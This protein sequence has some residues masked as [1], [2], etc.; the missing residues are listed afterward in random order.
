MNKPIIDDTNREILR[1]L[2]EN[3]RRPY[4]SIAKA[5]NLSTPS[6]SARIDQL[7]QN[8]VIRRFTIDLDFSQY[9][10]RLHVMVRLLPEFAKTESVRKSILNSTHIENVFT[11]AKGEI[12]VVGSLPRDSIGQWMLENLP[13]DE[14][15][16]YDVHLLSSATHT[17][18]SIG[19]ESALTCANCGSSVDTDGH[20]SR[21]GGRLQ[22]FCCDRCETAYREQLSRG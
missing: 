2:A 12:V 22:Q 7:V 19:T 13:L 9:E 16:R 18:Y 10:N 5:V 15:Q 11:T 6:V 1:L 14:V 17:P 21:V 20:A 4:R 3:A 8:G